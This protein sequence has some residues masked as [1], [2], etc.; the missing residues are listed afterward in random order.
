MSK[1]GGTGIMHRNKNALFLL[2]ALYTFCGIDKMDCY[3]TY[4]PF[5]VVNLSTNTTT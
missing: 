5:L 4:L 3:P 1:G 2:T